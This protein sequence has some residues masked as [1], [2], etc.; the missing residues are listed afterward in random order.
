MKGLNG[1][2]NSCKRR[3]YFYKSLPMWQYMS[4]LYVFNIDEVVNKI[5]C[6]IKSHFMERWMS[7]INKENSCQYAYVYNIF[8]FPI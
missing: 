4:P 8:I 2:K 7:V 1:I 6:A 5:E 3:F